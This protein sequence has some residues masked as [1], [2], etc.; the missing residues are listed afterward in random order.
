MTAND[1]GTRS[2]QKFAERVR[3][4]DR[5]TCQICGSPGRHVDH[6]IP[7]H[8]GGP[9]R[10]LGNTRVLCRL[11]NL[12]KGGSMMSDADVLAARRARGV[13]PAGRTGY[14]SASRTIFNR[15]KVF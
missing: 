6:K 3:R 1:L 8:L 4:R 12:I 11:C 5:N 14:G 2:Y 7:R 10:D 13:D 15:P 9:V